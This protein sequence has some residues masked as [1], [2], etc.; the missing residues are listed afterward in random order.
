MTSKQFSA[1]PTGR[2]LAMQMSF[3]SML[4]ALE[5]P[6]SPNSDWRAVRRIISSKP[7]ASALPETRQIEIFSELQR[8]AVAAAKLAAEQRAEAAAASAAAAGGS[9]VSSAITPATASVDLEPDD[10]HVLRMLRKEQVRDT[11][12]ENCS[13]AKK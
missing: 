7:I 4:E 13:L 5:E 8:E 9:S 1:L 12:S 6:I 3:R 11:R 10:V 2:L